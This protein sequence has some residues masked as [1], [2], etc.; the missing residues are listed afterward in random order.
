MEM[1]TQT[2][3]FTFIIQTNRD[4]HQETFKVTAWAEAADEAERIAKRDGFHVEDPDLVDAKLY[5]PPQ[6]I[7]GVRYFEVIPD[8]ET[9]S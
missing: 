4:V 1:E 5:V 7:V 3:E 9:S 2:R 8:N 6:A